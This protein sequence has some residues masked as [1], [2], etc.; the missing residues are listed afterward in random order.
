LPWVHGSV[1][2]GSMDALRQAEAE[3]IAAVTPAN[4]NGGH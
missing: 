4:V 3:F 2:A 1:D